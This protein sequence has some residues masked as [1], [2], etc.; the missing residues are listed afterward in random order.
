MKSD[1]IFH[2]P[3]AIAYEDFNCITGLNLQSY[4]DIERGFLEREFLEDQGISLKGNKPTRTDYLTKFSDYRTSFFLL[5]RT[6]RFIERRRYDKWA[7]L[8]KRQF[9]NHWNNNPHII[10]SSIKNPVD[11]PYCLEYDFKQW[12]EEAGKSDTF[13]QRKSRGPCMRSS[14]MNLDDSF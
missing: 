3:P 12:R 6:I 8:W 7:K 9:T 10:V 5:L 4:W 13:F 1:I 14:T 11:Y 2:L